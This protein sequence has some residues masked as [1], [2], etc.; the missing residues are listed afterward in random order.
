[1]RTKTFISIIAVTAF[2]LCLPSCFT[3]KTIKAYDGPEKDKSSLAIV[4][5]IDCPPKIGEFTRVMQIDVTPV[6][7]KT[8]YITDAKYS[9]KIMPGLHSIEIMHFQRDHKVIWFIGRY[10]V[11]F[12][13]EAGKTYII[14]ADTDPETNVVDVYVTDADSEERIESI[15]DY[16]YQIKEKE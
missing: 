9:F 13:A 7:R 8:P 11:S 12:N 2:L 16:K 5:G 4:K 3:N 6:T 14:N 1:M 15:V 10:L